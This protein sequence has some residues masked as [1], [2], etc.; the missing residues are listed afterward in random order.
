MSGAQVAGEAVGVTRSLTPARLLKLWHREAAL[1][2]EAD[3]V[4]PLVDRY[5]Q[6]RC[7][8]SAMADTME[9]ASRV[10]RRSD[11]FCATMARIYETADYDMMCDAERL[12]HMRRYPYQYTAA[13]LMAERDQLEVTLDWCARFARVAA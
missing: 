9:A 11:A 10:V 4:R 7:L 5:R 2:D 13:E 3:L 12:Q 6:G 8:T 1:L